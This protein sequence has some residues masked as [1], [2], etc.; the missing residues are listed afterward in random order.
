MCCVVW[1]GASSLLFSSLLF[2]FPLRSTQLDQISTQPNS[3]QLRGERNN[4]TRQQTNTKQSQKNNQHP[5]TYTYNN[6]LSYW[7]R[8]IVVESKFPSIHLPHPAPPSSARDQSTI[9]FDS[10]RFDS[11]ER[12]HPPI[13]GSNKSVICMHA[14]PCCMREMLCWLDWSCELIVARGVGW[15][16]LKESESIGLDWLGLDQRGPNHRHTHTQRRIC[17]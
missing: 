13:T 10:I 1:C 6:I 11:R 15:A 5:Y 3:I 14:M 8:R 2:C 7:L 12:P 9:R 16:E 17:V 4:P